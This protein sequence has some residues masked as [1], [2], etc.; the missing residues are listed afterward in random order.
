MPP[1]SSKKPGEENYLS[2]L[3]LCV[4]LLHYLNLGCI[5]RK[6]IRELHR[7]ATLIQN[8]WRHW[9]AFRNSP[10]AAE[11]KTPVEK[12]KAKVHLIQAW[13]KPLH[14]K[15]K[16][17]NSNYAQCK[18]ATDIQRVWR[19]I[20]TLLNLIGYSLRNLLVPQLREKLSDL[21]KLIRTHRKQ[22][23]EFQSAYVLQNAWRSFIAKKVQGEKKKIR[24]IAAS[25]IQALWKG[26]W[27]RAHALS[28]FSYG[29]AVY[30]AAVRKGLKNSHFILKAY[31]PCGLVCP[32]SETIPTK[33]LDPG[34]AN[35][36][37]EESM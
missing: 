32:K 17:R 13:W 19:G 10:I 24:N 33:L 18:A 6:P 21:G 37:L 16:E 1:L 25:R 12:L 14:L 31:K 26:F 15:R 35:T 23:F 28:M 34:N 29:Q 8:K 36:N 30:L 5:Y 27:T 3:Q 22:L 4:S 20:F 7:C 11:Y 2:K 9:H